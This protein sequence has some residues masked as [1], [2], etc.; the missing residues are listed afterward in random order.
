MALVLF[1]TNILIDALKGYTPAIEELAYWDEPAISVITWMEVMAG[2]RDDYDEVLGFLN[3]FGFEVIHTNEAIMIASME[4]R[5]MSIQ[6]RHK[7]AL[8]DAIIMGTA[9]SCRATIVTRNKKDFFTPNVRIPYELTPI[10]PVE[11]INVDPPPGLSS[12]S[13]HLG[14]DFFELFAKTILGPPQG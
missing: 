8:P 2:T 10:D 1:D 7:V 6:M 14:D 11:F 4:V 3:S 9:L 12:S 13:E 5:R